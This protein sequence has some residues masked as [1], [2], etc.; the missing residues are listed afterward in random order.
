MVFVSKE[1]IP[2]STKWMLN[3][4]LRG[5][6]LP[7][8]CLAAVC[9]L[10]Q[11][12]QELRLTLGKSI[13][14]DYPADIGRISTSN[15]EVVDYVAVSTRE[16]LVHAKSHGTASLIVWSRSG[17]RD[18]YTI[19]VE[20]N[21][22]PIRSILK[23]TFPNEEIE[24][25]AARDTISLTG[26]VS[27]QQVADRAVAIVTPLAKTVVNNLRLPVPKSEKQVMLRVRFAELN[28]NASSSFSA[29]LVSTGAG[30]TIGRTTAG[31]SPAPIPATIGGNSSSNGFTL[32]DALNVFAF[33]P[34]FNL[35]A[36]VQALQ[37]RGVLQILAE[38]NLVTS[39]GK[40]AS[41]LVGGEFPVPILQGGANAGAVTVQ[42]REFGIRLTFNPQITENNTIKLFVKP[43]VNTLDLA[44]SVSIA[45]FNIPALAT[46][47]IETNIELAEGQSFVIGGLIDDR[48][49]ESMSRIP[50]LSSIPL[51]GMLFR[52]RSENKSK[53]ELLVIVTPEVTQP[54]APGALP[55]D[56]EFP[57]QF[58]RDM[59]SE[60]ASLKST[61]PGKAG[62]VAKKESS[63]GNEGAKQAP[64]AGGEASGVPAE[65]NVTSP[66]VREGAHE[67]E[68]APA[69]AAPVTPELS[70][71]RRWFLPLRQ[72]ARQPEKRS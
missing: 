50:G 38:P 18:F 35:A 41:F 61:R 26:N 59:P 13:V 65:D 48:V 39:N 40:E 42:F 28:R 56:L 63:R 11:N 3:L 4:R 17:Q 54:G 71:R 53:S 8:L 7:L 32:T 62:Q 14:I 9:A 20:H 29:H 24:L 68:S 49:T 43:E 70:K 51:L 55:K 58:L 57:R 12:P 2:M 21:L 66:A 64:A 31:G 25:Q 52:S 15:P 10:A 33:R 69:A 47:R 22:E 67:E 19:N 44:N 45:G 16:I 46:R 5:K 60:A 37:A 30:N 27:T 1:R 34:Q 6:A 23:A 72:S 36:V